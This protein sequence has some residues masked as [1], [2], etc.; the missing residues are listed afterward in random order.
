[1]NNDSEVVIDT[2]VLRTCLLEAKLYKQRNRVRKVQSKQ[3]VN[4][5]WS[6]EVP[7]IDH[8]YNRIE[9]VRNFQIRSM[10]DEMREES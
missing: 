3:N 2:S 5:K 9:N 8:V 4:G 7:Q 10:C 1:M 6:G